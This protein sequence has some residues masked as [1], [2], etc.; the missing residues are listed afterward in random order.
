MR[1]TVS[2]S[3]GAPCARRV[4]ERGPDL[5]AATRVISTRVARSLRAIRS[6]APDATV[7][8]VGY[9]RLVPDR[10]SCAKLPLATGDYAEGRRISR[11]LDR[12]LA[13]AARRAGVRFVD[14]YEV[15][16]GHDICSADPWVNGS[17]TDRDRAL[18][19]HPFA[20]GMRADADQVLKALGRR[21]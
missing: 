10:G 11:V 15:S 21:S 14:M 20:S 9:L 7:L 16:R 1:S 17:T 6:K 5:A 18:S 12:A 2:T 4:A 19:Y 3:D 13:Q 8:L